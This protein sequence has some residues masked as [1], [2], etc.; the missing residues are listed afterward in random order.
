MAAILDFKIQ[1]ACVFGYFFSYGL[2]E[3]IYQ[4]GP[5]HHDLKLKKLNMSTI[6]LSDLIYSF[7]SFVFAEFNRIFLNFY[8]Q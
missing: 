6:K 3:F 8:F 7:Y 2:G 1:L 5:L 4:R